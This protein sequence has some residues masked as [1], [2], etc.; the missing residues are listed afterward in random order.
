MWVRPTG[1]FS[2]WLASLINSLK[3]K[4]ARSLRS[5]CITTAP[6]FTLGG[7]LG[8][9][10]VATAQDRTV[11]IKMTPPGNP[12][13]DYCFGGNRDC[14]GE[15]WIGLDDPWGK[16]T[17]GCCAGFAAWTDLSAGGGDESF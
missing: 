15:T 2:S 4:F 16:D 14:G 17:A 10:N 5:A 11:E 8:K 13:T 1:E 6:A 9:S 7:P 12:T 3:Q